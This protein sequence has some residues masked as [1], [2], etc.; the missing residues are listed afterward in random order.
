MSMG[1]RLIG[2]RARALLASVPLLL[3]SSQALA[4]PF[5]PVVPPTCPTTTN[6]PWKY[7][8]GGGTYWFDLPSDP[9]CSSSPGNP[10][11]H[12]INALDHRRF[13]VANRWVGYVGFRLEGFNTESGYDVMNWGLENNPLF[14]KSGSGAAGTILY[15]TTAASFGSLRALLNYKTDYSVTY[16]GFSFNQLRVC[17]Y[18]TSADTAAP[19]QLD[20]SRRYHGVLLG[21]GDTVYLKFG[22]SSA[23][24]YPITLWR[25]MGGVIA[26]SGAMDYDLYTRCGALPTATQY[27]ARS[28]SS[29]DQEFIDASNCNGTMYVAVNVHNQAAP[30]AFNLVRGIHRPTGH[31][32]LRVGVTPAITSAPVLTTLGLNLR[33]SSR[34]FYGFTE[35]EQMVTQIDLYNNGSCAAGSCGGSNCDICYHSA[36]YGRANSGLCG[37]QINLWLDSTNLT[38]AHE[39]GHLKFCA[40][41]EYVDDPGPPPTQLEKCGH[42]VMANITSDNFNL[43]TYL[44]HNRDGT[45]GT[46]PS[47]L[48]PGWTQAFNAGKALNNENLTF[49]NHPYHVHDFDNKVGTV[50]T[51]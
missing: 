26:N 15:V 14:S 18:R 8:V 34:Y 30:G 50:I 25:D 12:Y 17:T 41:D 45:P 10:C 35:G 42:T 5:N 49:D 44:D 38:T 11:P 6:I 20:L 13:F 1:E 29:D 51:H 22:A 32:P 47:A 7:T 36:E 24:H 33:E 28:Y 4:A 2:K 31:V 40:G 39:L 43:C 3:A 16:P 46:P 19:A 9:N 23:Y 27:D 48:T 37:G 21:Y